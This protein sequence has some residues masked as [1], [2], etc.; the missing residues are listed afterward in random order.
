M[1]ETQQ[2]LNHYVK[3]GSEEAFGELV[4]RYIDLV[5][6]AAVRLVDG[7]THLAEDVTQ[8]VFVDL[9]RTARTLR[10]EVMLGGWLHRHTC[11][12]AAKALRAQRRRRFHERQAAQM[13][14]SKDHTAANLAQIRPF[15]DEAINGLG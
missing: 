9:A 15:L 11:F 7:D 10:S 13:N 3:D 8:T 6:S 5:Y 2:L 4:K 12:V 1:S 14:E